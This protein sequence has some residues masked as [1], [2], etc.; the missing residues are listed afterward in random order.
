T[1]TDI[2]K[3]L[4]INKTT[5]FRNLKTLEELNIIEKINHLYYLDVSLFELGNKVYLKQIIVEKIHPILK[6]LSEEVNETVNLAKL[7]NGMVLYLDKIESRRSLQ[8]QSSIGDTL[9]IYCTSLGKSILSILPDEKMVETI[10]N[11]CFN[12]TTSKTIDKPELLKKQISEIKKRGYSIDDEEYE[13]GLTC[14]SVPLF[15]EHHNFYGSISLS[16]PS[17]R[18]DQATILKFSGKLKKYKKIITNKL[19]N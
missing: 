19:K 5:A 16:G 3:I 18:F 2:V 13:E 17:I 4:N 11:I 12:K 7:H 10:N 6:E 14:I 8:I 15:L 1:L 9:P